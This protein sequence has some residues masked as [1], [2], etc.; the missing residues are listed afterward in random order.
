MFFHLCFVCF[1]FLIHII[2]RAEIYFLISGTPKPP[3]F[4]LFT[5]VLRLILSCLLFQINLKHIFCRLFTKSSGGSGSR[6]QRCTSLD[7]IRDFKMATLPSGL[8]SFLTRCWTM[9]SLQKIFHYF[10]FI[11]LQ[12]FRSRVNHTPNFTYILNWL[13]FETIFKWGIYLICERLLLPSQIACVFIYI[14][15]QTRYF[16]VLFDCI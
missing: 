2:F 4:T 15:K 7:S 1:S 3:L 8:M 11:F 14:Q 13:G 5:A 9:P 6:I 16:P 10:Y 12:S